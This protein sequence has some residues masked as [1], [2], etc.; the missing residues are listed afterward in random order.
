MATR[1]TNADGNLTGVST[2]AAAE[3]GA[4]ATVL[5]RFSNNTMAAATTLTSVTFTVTNAAVIDGVL[6]FL[7]QGAAGS[8]GT[9]KVD[10]QKAG[11][12]QASVTVNKADLV[13]ATAASVLH[14]VFFK[15]T[16]TAIGDGAA[17]WT[18]VFTTTGTNTVIIATASA[19][20]TNFTRGLRT[21]TAA[22][23]AAA[24][25]FYV[26]GELTG[27][28]THASRAVTMDSIATTA[29]GSGALNSTTVAGGGI[30]IG[31]YGS[32]TYGNSASTN[33]VLRV[34]GDVFVYQNG[35]F[36][37]GSVGAEIPRNSTAVFEIQPTATLVCAVL[38]AAL[39]IRPACRARQARTLSSAS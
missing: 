11:V 24:D 22:T 8:T 12:S 28:G 20:T 30:H 26:L 31:Q 27:A 18:L 14:P 36:N 4:L 17:T 6:L 39:S 9:F 10:L 19:T 1:I 3:T 13:D 35:T 29:Y 38:K 7:R 16:S 32:L 15:L 23:L 34:N 2:F 25:D 33:Y 37:I 21:T 5:N